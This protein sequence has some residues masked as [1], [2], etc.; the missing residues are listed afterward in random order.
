MSVVSP[1]A[2]TLLSFA[3]LVLHIKLVQ[4]KLLLSFAYELS[5]SCFDIVNCERALAFLSD[6]Q[7]QGRL[8]WS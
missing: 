8:W 2:Q 3:W 6:E 1:L 7:P 5:D 4:R